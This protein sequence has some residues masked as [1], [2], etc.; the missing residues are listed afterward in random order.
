MKPTDLSSALRRIA[1]KI[2]ASKSPSRELVLK[3]LNSL[4]RKMAM[5]DD[6]QDDSSL[7][8]GVHEVISMPNAEFT[9]TIDC[10]RGSSGVIGECTI[11]I[12]SEW[13]EI[14][15]V[16]SAVQSIDREINSATTGEYWAMVPDNLPK[17]AR[18]AT[19]GWI[20]GYLVW[21]LENGKFEG[22]PDIGQFIFKFDV[23]FEG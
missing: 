18:S 21:C 23:L 19:D 5:D 1:S 4:V 6:S 8:T 9:V 20:T 12:Q 14:P 15:S 10:T 3:D 7:P 22:Q 2:E 17:A 16:V 13:S 11:Q